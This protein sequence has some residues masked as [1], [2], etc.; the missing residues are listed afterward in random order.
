V[1]KDR[2]DYL[3]YSTEILNRKHAG[4]AV[5]RYMLGGGGDV[6][7]VYVNGQL[8]GDSLNKKKKTEKTMPMSTAKTQPTST[9]STSLPQEQQEASSRRRL[10]QVTT[11]PPRAIEVTLS[12]PAGNSTLDLLSVSMGLNN[13]GPYLDKDQVGIISHLSLDGVPIAHHDDVLQ[14]V[15][16]STGLLGE[17]LNLS[18]PFSTP[19]SASVTYS[20]RE[21]KGGVEYEQDCTQLCW[22]QQT[23]NTP[24]SV[25]EDSSSSSA[26]IGSLAID[27]GESE[28][29]K[30]SLWVNGHMLGRYWT[31]LADAAVSGVDCDNTDSCADISYVGAYDPVRCRSGCGEPSQRYYKLPTSW[32]NTAADT[33]S[34]GISSGSS[35]STYKNSLVVFDEYGGNPKGIQLVHIEMTTVVRTSV[36]ERK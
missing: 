13:Y 30:G 11:N 33:S 26:S 34:S 36:A 2:T 23:F 19:A 16:H 31:V 14:P 6:S 28:L 24:Q 29:V 17:Y 27:L 3:W 25:V 8:M 9:R 18:D 5:L 32:L 35:A 7:Y 15:L 1:T 12:L 20:D 10:K 22:Y 4:E 21:E